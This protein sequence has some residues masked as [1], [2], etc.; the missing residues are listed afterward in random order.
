MQ[1]ALTPRQAQVYTTVKR[2]HEEY[3]KSPTIK[4][5]CNRMDVKWPNAVYEL[6]NGLEMKGYIFRRK[7]AKRNIELRNVDALSMSTSTVSIPVVASVGCDDLSVIADEKYDESI[8]V[9]QSILEG[10]GK[11]AAVRAVGDSMNDADINDG[12][13]ILI[14]LTENAQNGDRVAVIVGDM[15]TVKR[16]ERKNGFTVLRPESKDP[17]YKPIILR[18]D[19]KI[20]GKV[21]GVVSNPNVV[22]TEIFPL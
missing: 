9:D 3:G 13:Y 14:E 17:K 20:A 4:E 5:L 6:L 1:K 18:E 15:V 21:I 10:K 2:F 8:E 22:Q 7:N 11:I 16:L 19:F 12:D